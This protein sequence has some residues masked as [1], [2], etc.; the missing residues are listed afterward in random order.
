[1]KRRKK[2]VSLRRRLQC[3]IAWTVLVTAVLAAIGTVFLIIK[4][5]KKMCNEVFQIDSSMAYVEEQTNTS[6]S[7]STQKT[8][9]GG[10]VENT[11]N[12]SESTA[13]KSQLSDK[14]LMLVNKDHP[15]SDSYQTELHLLKN[16]QYVA[17]D[18][19]EDL[20]DM[21]F[22]G[23]EENPGL[24]FLVASGYRTETKQQKLLDEE[25]EKNQNAGMD[26]QEAYEDALQSVAPAGYSEHETGLCVDIVAESNQ[27]L[28]ETQ[29]YTPENEWLVEHCA[30][31]GFILRYPA[32]KE[33]ITGFMFESWHFRYVGKEAA[34]EITEKGI[35]L[36]EY[37]GVI[38]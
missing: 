2:K 21:L 29:Q 12:Q 30:E 8:K 22:T 32:G 33:E 38:E 13:N 31:Y 35:T 5:A 17:E 27:R 16:G 20:R 24:S 4:T 7:S 11:G 14:L 34:K 19:Y 23:E 37:L 25:I 3:Y 9:S 18:M 10:T 36:E 28:D 1:M 26:E 15:L 6:Q